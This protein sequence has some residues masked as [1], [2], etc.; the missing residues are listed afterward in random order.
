MFNLINNSHNSST[1]SQL[2]HWK[3]KKKIIKE[4]TEILNHKFTFISSTSTSLKDHFCLTSEFQDFAWFSFFFFRSVVSYKDI[5]VTLWPKTADKK[6]IKSFGM[7]SL[8]FSCPSV[9]PCG[10]PHTLYHELN[11]LWRQLPPSG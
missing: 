11:P 2:V 8:I 4:E 9:E 10:T 3:Q 6:W 7:C 1:Q 5:N